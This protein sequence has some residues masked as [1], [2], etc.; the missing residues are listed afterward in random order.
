[1][2]NIETLRA[3]LKEAERA[4]QDAVEAKRSSVEQIWVF[5]I[6]PD[7]GQRRYDKMWDD[8]VIFYRIT[9]HLVNRPEC[10]AVGQNLDRCG[11]G[12]GMSY[13]Y[14][15]LS[16]KI[17]CSVGGGQVWVGMGW[18]EDERESELIAIN[19]I[20]AFILEHPDGGDITEI[21][22]NH[23]ARKHEIRSKKKHG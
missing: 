22:E 1:M 14:N 4:E 11:D 13:F 9:G 15:T 6:N 2:S 18:N 21:I 10:E 3:Q 5:A 16:K 17:V 7:E 23:Q 12:Q 19:E 8:S 20:N